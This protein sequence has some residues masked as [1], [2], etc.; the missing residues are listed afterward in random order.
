[1]LLRNNLDSS[2]IDSYRKK[3]AQKLLEEAKKPYCHTCQRRFDTKQELDNH[4][5]DD[6]DYS[7]YYRDT[8]A[9]AEL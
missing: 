7:D 9:R 1:M 6:F 3:A 4:E 8:E 2:V 5:C